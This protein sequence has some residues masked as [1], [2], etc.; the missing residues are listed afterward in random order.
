MWFDQDDAFQAATEGRPLGERNDSIYYE[1]QRTSE[2][3]WGALYVNYQFNKDAGEEGE[4]TL[5]VA[6]YVPG[7]WERLSRRFDQERYGL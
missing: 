2:R 4:A 6:R 1:G 5:V 7:L 3:P